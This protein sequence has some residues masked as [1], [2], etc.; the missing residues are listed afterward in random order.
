MVY[1]ISL[2][3]CRLVILV[4]SYR[5]NIFRMQFAYGMDG[6]LKIYQ[7]HGLVVLVLVYNIA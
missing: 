5:S 7:Q 1:Q 3:H 6:V 2:Q 4:S